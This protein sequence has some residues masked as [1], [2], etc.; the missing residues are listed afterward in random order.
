MPDASPPVSD[1]NPLIDMFWWDLGQN[2][3]IAG[4]LHDTGNV[5]RNVQLVGN[6][7]KALVARVERLTLVCMALCSLLQEKTN[8]TRQDLLDRVRQIDLS[9]GRLDGKFEIMARC[10]QCGALMSLRHPRCLYCGG[11]PLP[12]RRNLPPDELLQIT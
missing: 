9:D 10:A 3:R 6:E 11:E 12:D 8:V 2:M 1:S 5:D 7:L 4:A